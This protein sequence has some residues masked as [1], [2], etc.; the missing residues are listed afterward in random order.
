MEGEWQTLHSRE[1]A[2]NLLQEY[3]TSTMTMFSCYTSDK[4]LF[5]CYSSDKGLFSKGKHS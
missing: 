1:E 5:S 2:S 4:G 3:E